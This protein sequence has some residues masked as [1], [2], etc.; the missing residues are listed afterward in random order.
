MEVISRSPEQTRRIGMRLGPFLKP[1]DVLCLEGD[2][3]SGKTTLIQGIASGW[4]STD[5]AS[6]PTFVLVNVYRQPEGRRLYHLD[7]YRMSGPKE[8]EDLDLDTMVEDGPMVVEWA[9]RIKDAL[10]R[11]HM[12]ATLKWVDD[13]QRDFTFTACGPRYEALLALFRKQVYGG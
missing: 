6:S 11:E 2:L 4:G 12:W 8:A 5:Q 10:P 9:D 3:G 1:G 13:N 7:A